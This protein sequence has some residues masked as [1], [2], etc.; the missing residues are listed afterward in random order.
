MQGYDIGVTIELSS[1]VNRCA[2]IHSLSRPAQALEPK[3][4]LLIRQSLMA[5]I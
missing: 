3:Y 5:K 2:D 4:G 1:D